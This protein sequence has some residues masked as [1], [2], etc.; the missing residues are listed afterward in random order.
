[1]VGGQDELVLL[2]GELE[3]LFKM[4]LWKEVEERE[5]WRGYH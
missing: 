3:T 2:Q 1:M 4:S 5:E